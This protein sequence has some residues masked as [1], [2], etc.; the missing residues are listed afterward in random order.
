MIRDNETREAPGLDREGARPKRPGIAIASNT[1][2]HV[3]F[4]AASSASNYNE[5]GQ[6]LRR[7][8]TEEAAWRRMRRKRRKT[9]P[10][11][12]VGTSVARSCRHDIHQ[13][14]VSA[15]LR[16]ASETLSRLLVPCVTRARAAPA[17]H[18]HRSLS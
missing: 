7:A 14:I 4:P 2:V 1:D 6:I 12:A 16:R 13:R 18:A 8:F 11:P 9:P 5:R 17:R 15:Q 3:D 10:P